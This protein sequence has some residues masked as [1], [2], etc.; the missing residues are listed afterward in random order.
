[1]RPLQVAGLADHSKANLWNRPYAHNKSIQLIIAQGGLLLTQEM[2][3][4]FLTKLDMQAD[5]PVENCWTDTDAH[6]L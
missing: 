6:M 1:M 4:M 3:A 2:Q 5:M